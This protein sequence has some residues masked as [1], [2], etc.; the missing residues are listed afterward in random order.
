MTDCL[1]T[2]MTNV[3]KT[4][5]VINFADYMGLKKLK[6]H[7]KQVA[8]YTAI[9]SYTPDE[10]RDKLISIDENSTID[11]QQI[12]L[13]IPRGKTF[14]EL[15]IIDSCGLTEG[16]HPEEEIRLAMAKTIHL[17]RTSKCILHIIDIS[18]INTEVE[19]P[20]L[21]IDKM[22]LDYACNKQ[23]YAILANKIDLI[24][25]SINLEILKEKVSDVVII[26][27]SALYKQG[28]NDIREMVLSYV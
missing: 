24:Y 19:N 6:F 7:V 11:I 12:K 23:N 21:P 27:I 26:P 9:N 17:I 18:T 8:G 10:A 25:A 4:S 1:V 16:I 28:F 13:K 20:L 15:T 3:G 14:K 22:I 2:G 5:F